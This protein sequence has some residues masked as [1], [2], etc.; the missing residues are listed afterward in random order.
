MGDGRKV[1]ASWIWLLFYFVPATPICPA[2]CSCRDEALAAAC[3]EAGL[4][5]IPNLLNPGVEIIDLSG[6]RIS[7]FHHYALNI[8]A[9]LKKLDVSLNKIQT[10][11]SKNFEAQ[12]K[13]EVMNVSNNQITTLGKDAFR[14]LK[15]L[16]TLDLSHNRIDRVKHGSFKDTADLQVIDLSHNKLISFE[17]PTVFSAITSLKSLYLHSNQII[18]V[19]SAL[20]KNL[21]HPCVLETLTLTDNLIEAIEGKSFPSPC[22][23]TLKYLSLGSNVIKDIEKSAFN[24]LYNLKQLDLSFNNLTFIPTQQLAKL[25]LL[26]ELDLSGNTFSSVRPV[27]FQSLFQLKTLRLC[28]MPYMER[29]DS[30][31]FVDNTRLEAVV[32]DDNLQL[33]RIPT[34]IFYRNSQLRYVSMKSNALTTLDA[35]HFPLD[36]LRV[37]DLSDNPLYCNCSLH[38]LWDMAQVDSKIINATPVSINNDSTTA[39]PEEMKPQLRVI[40]T[41]LRC[42][43]PESLRGHLLTEIPES[44]VRCEATWLTVAIITGL[45]LALFAATCVVLLLFGSERKLCWCKKGKQDNDPTV[46][47]RRLAAGLHAPSG[48]PPILMLMPEKH[49]RDAILTNYMKSDGDIKMVEPWLNGESRQNEYTVDMAPARKKPHIVYV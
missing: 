19:P 9:N 33:T 46:D 39:S 41:D 28:K 15:S 16:R 31:A 48:P 4:E 24:S 34:R 17:D 38:W 36:Q 47:T 3:V 44:T 21:P 42:A 12:G 45:V 6:N 35:S 13:L 7:G 20:L 26:S 2:K 27:A 43:N 23:N 18:D 1:L 32:I 25:N 49:Y 40:V 8:Y 14:G 5:V 29:I 30:R 22:T 11:G 37:L 10:L